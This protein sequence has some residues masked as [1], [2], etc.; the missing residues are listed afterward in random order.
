MG[1]K[2]CGTTSVDKTVVFLPLMP[3]LRT[4][5]SVADRFTLRARSG[6]EHAQHIRGL[7]TP[8]RSLSLHVD[9]RCATAGR[10]HHKAGSP[11]MWSGPLGVVVLV[12][13]LVGVAGLAY[14]VMRTSGAMPLPRRPDERD[15][16]DV[17]RHTPH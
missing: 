17:E 13:I 4:C 6:P 14:F 2:C 9:V 1:L 10:A 12:I 5:A 8:G 16:R 7:K 15:T 3:Q 11:K